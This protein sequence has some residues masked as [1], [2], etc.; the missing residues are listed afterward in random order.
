MI[1]EKAADEWVAR[2]AYLKPPGWERV[3]TGSSGMEV[4]GGKKEAEHEKV[5]GK[6]KGGSKM[7]MCKVGVDDDD[8]DS[9]GVWPIQDGWM[10]LDTLDFLTIESIDAQVGWTGHVFETE[11][12]AVAMIGCDAR[13]LQLDL[14]V[15]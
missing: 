2:T 4:R 10:L 12:G 3:E 7:G 13:Q 6:K 14:A 15:K 11:N 8:D 5:K 9:V 1:G